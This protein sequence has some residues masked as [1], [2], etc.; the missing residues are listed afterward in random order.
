MKQKTSRTTS[1]A[2]EIKIIKITIKIIFSQP[3]V[4]CCGPIPVI[5]FTLL[6]QSILQLHKYFHTSDGQC[7]WRPRT[8]RHISYKLVFNQAIKILPDMQIV[9]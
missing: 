9:N 3:V 6:I 2:E 8:M 4:A 7:E 1:V 5:V